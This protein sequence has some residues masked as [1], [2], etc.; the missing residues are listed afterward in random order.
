MSGAVWSCVEPVWGLHLCW[1]FTVIWL[2]AGHC[3]DSCVHVCA[4]WYTFVST[5][6]LFQLVAYL[7]VL[8]MKVIDFL[9]SWFLFPFEI[10]SHYIAPAGTCY[11]DQD[12][13]ELAFGGRHALWWLHWF[14]YSG[15]AWLYSFGMCKLPSVH[16]LL[17][18]P[19]HPH[20]HVALY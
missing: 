1:S 4:T 14:C 16:Y 8:N 7:C 15:G 2:S 19:T 18:V 17:P 5:D 3:T 10:E 20:S 9:V 12:G 11:V 13:V 6:I